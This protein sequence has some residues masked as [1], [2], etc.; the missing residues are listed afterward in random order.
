MNPKFPLDPYPAFPLA[1]DESLAPPQ[2]TCARGLDDTS[3][4][5]SDKFDPPIRQALAVCVGEDELR[6]GFSPVLGVGEQDWALLKPD[7]SRALPNVGLY[8]ALAGCGSSLKQR[9][10]HTAGSY[11][12]HHVHEINKL[13]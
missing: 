12:I 10:I 5:L 11:P 4:F 6:R 8:L 9:K 2:E 1:E 3:P 13:G 7:R